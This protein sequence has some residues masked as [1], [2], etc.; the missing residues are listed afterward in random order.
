MNKILPSILL[1]ILAVTVWIWNENQSNRI[2]FSVDS[3]VEPTPSQR[4]QSPVT[5]ARRTRINQMAES[6]RQKVKVVVE[7][8][9]TPSTNTY[10]M[11]LDATGSY[12]PDLGDDVFFRWYQTSGPQVDL[13]P[14]NTSPKVSFEGV[15]GEY[16][17]ELT[18]SDNYGAQNT[19]RK[20]VVIEPEP[21]VPPVINIKVRQGSELK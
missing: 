19:I 18:V 13:K 6:E 7:H 11:I 5:E 21:N 16:E 15:A 20:T 12:D 17:F 2:E 3:V 1:A 9:N 14:S 8:D 4:I 10:P